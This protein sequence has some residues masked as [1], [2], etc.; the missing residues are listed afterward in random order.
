MHAGEDV[1]EGLPRSPAGS[2]CV[3]LRPRS[4][5][6]SKQFPQKP[7]RGWFEACWRCSGFPAARDARRYAVLQVWWAGESHPRHWPGGAAATPTAWGAPFCTWLLPGCRG[8]SARFGESP[9]AV[10]RQAGSVP[11]RSEP[12]CRPGALCRGDLCVPAVLDVLRAREARGWC[13]AGWRR[14]GQR[15]GRAPSC[16]TPSC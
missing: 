11:V 2:P 8:R 9:G 15:A 7:A 13:S 3:A 12:Q 5:A 4:W 10:L 16:P 14:R 1:T 6:L